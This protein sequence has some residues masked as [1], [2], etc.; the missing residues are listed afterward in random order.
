MPPPTQSMNYQFFY[1]F[2][3]ARSIAIFR[4]LNECVSCCIHG[5]NRHLIDFFVFWP[6]RSD[7]HMICTCL[8]TYE[9]PC[10]QRNG[11][12]QQ[13]TEFFICLETRA[14]RVKIAVA[15]PKRKKIE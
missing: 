10:K 12:L 2:L 14:Y 15:E 11:C 6:S 13:S 5:E 9:K 8:K 4:V 3:F 7:F 1:I